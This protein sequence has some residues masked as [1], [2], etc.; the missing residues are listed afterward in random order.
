MPMKIL[1]INKKYDTI[2]KPSQ[3]YP[4]ARMAEYE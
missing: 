4:S 1:L 2:D 3:L